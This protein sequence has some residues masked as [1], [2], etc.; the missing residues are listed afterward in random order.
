MN[1]YKQTLQVITRGKGLYPM[2]EQVAQSI[3]TWKVVEGV[4]FLYIPH[5]SASLVI[6]ESYDPTAKIDIEVF[7]EKLVPE[8]QPWHRHTLEGKD[9]SPSHMKSILT[10]T[11]ITIPID[12]GELSLGTWQGIY[13]F[14]HRSAGHRRQVLLRCL[15]FNGN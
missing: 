11:S 13:L 10:H 4:C 9:D 14:E 6:N 12:D 3:H 8:N 5:T 15:A 7:M 2:T 1:W